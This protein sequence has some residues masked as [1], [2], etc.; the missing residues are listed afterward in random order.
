MAQTTD[1]LPMVDVKIEASSDF[2]NWEDISGFFNSLTRSGG[3]RSAGDVHTADG[4]TVI[5]KSGKRGP[6]DISGRIVYTE[7]AGD[8]WQMVRTEFESGDSFWIRW[9]PKGGSVG[10]WQYTTDENNSVLLE[11][12]E[13]VGDF[14]DGTPV[15]VTFVVHTAKVDKAAVV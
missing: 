12:P 15:L 7:G 2:S 5:T 1:G 13:P 11:C 8:A 6:I 3:A 14:A 4:D 10:D 9:S